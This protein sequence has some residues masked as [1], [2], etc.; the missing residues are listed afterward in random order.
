MPSAIKQRF[1]FLKI[2]KSKWMPANRTRFACGMF[3]QR[4]DAF[5][6]KKMTTF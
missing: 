6:V 3:F 4:N 2:I 1:A 5:L